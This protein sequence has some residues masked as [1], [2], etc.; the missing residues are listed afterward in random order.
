MQ[1]LATRVVANVRGANKCQLIRP[2]NAVGVPTAPGRLAA[3]ANMLLA[4]PGISGVEPAQGV[5]RAAHAV[6]PPIYCAPRGEC[7]R[8]DGANPLLNP[9][10]AS[11]YN[12]LSNAIE[13]SIGRLCR[14]AKICRLFGLQL[15]FRA[16]RLNRK[17][18][19]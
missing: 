12:C 2:S 19:K 5:R 16:Y 9:D 1:W 3:A 7:C 4:A 15:F 18:A 13:S 10:A 6:A 11:P 14:L 8:T 17:R